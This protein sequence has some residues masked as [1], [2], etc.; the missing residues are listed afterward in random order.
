M[1]FEVEVEVLLV[2][3]SR[4][5]KRTAKRRQRGAKYSSEPTGTG[6]EPLPSRAGE[7]KTANA[8][9]ER[10]AAIT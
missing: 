2:S 8:W 6:C 1:G 7:Q 9:C 10:T 3:W 4:R 5:A